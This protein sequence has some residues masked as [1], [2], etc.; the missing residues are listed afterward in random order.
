MPGYANVGSGLSY[1]DVVNAIQTVGDHHQVDLF[2]EL[3]P[4]N[5]T[6]RVFAVTLSAKER[7]GLSGSQQIGQAASPRYWVLEAIAP[8][9]DPQRFCNWLYRLVLEM[10][11][12]LSRER[13]AQARM[14]F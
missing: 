14:P 5:S 13:W 4:R 8:S 9:D 12:K 7:H 3:F 11:F 1:W 10:D 2:I 6:E